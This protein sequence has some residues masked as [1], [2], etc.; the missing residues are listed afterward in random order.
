MNGAIDKL[1]YALRHDLVSNPYNLYMGV[2]GNRKD[3]DEF[4]GVLH[5][6]ADGRCG[7][8]EQYEE[9]AQRM[10][11][12]IGMNESKSNKN[13]KKNVVKINENTLRQI[14]AESVK[15]VL[16][17]G[18]Y[19]DLYRKGNEPNESPSYEEKTE[20]ARKQLWDAYSELAQF[21]NTVAVNDK[22][23]QDLWRHAMEAINNLGKRC[24]GDGWHR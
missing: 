20:Y 3:M 1:L 4:R 2:F 16:N 10:L 11:N 24:F 22:D 7:Y 17:E 8:P 5:R 18:Q 19:T 14:V 23:I 21:Q 9:N 13:M 6:Y 12:A 15:N